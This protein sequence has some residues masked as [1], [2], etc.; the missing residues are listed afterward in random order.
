MAVKVYTSREITQQIQKTW[1]WVRKLPEYKADFMKM[2]KHRASLPP[3]PPPGETIL[4]SEQPKDEFREHV[5]QLWGF[6]PLDD[7][8]IA[9]PSSAFTA[10]LTAA[11]RTD[12]VMIHTELTRTYEEDGLNASPRMSLARRKQL[13]GAPERIVY[14]IDPTR[15]I[16][17]I[18]AIIGDHLKRV[19]RA[20][21][22]KRGK[23]RMD[24][25]FSRYQAYI[26][27][28][29]GHADSFIRKQLMSKAEIS[30]SYLNY[31]SYL[32]RAKRDI[33]ASKE[34]S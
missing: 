17:V 21:K 26:L 27:R 22:I 4:T 31:D 11:F 3:Y 28:K 15:P 1:N 19:R 18:Q 32:E 34:M 30:P 33:R 20:Y 10:M 29:L 24:S 2:R 7:P 23:P 13:S 6:Y 5:T 14:A 16:G 12:A 9:W 25:Q 8:K